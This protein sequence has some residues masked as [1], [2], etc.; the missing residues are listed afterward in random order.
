M[1][2]LAP[3]FAPFSGL[4]VVSLAVACGGNVVVDH[5][6]S[7]G[8]GGNGGT[9]STSTLSAMGGSTSDVNPITT[10]PQVGPGVGGNSQVGP[11]PGPSVTTGPP[12]CDCNLF[13]K[14]VVPCLMGQL[15]QGQCEMLC[16]GGQIPQNAITC[17]CNVGM[18]CGAIFQQC[19]M[20][21]PGASSV[22]PGPGPGASSSVGPGTGTGGSGGGP[23]MQCTDCANMA[24]QSD[25]MMQL[26]DCEQ[27]QG[28]VDLINCEQ[29]CNF[30]PMCVDGCKA[31]HGPNS[32]MRAQAL[33]QCA[34]CGQCTMSCAGSDLFTEACTLPP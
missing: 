18:D 26:T 11:G 13:C 3:R 30:D 23:S 9:H 34:V 17:V 29:S 28:C 31:Q 15:T 14:D 8:T 5:G 2:K 4:V 7:Q 21:G 25:C 20:M 32:N 16:N 22:G 33:L 10:G 19:A 12:Q 24:A 6:S 1:K 27:H